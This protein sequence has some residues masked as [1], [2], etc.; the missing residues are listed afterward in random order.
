MRQ[1]PTTVRPYKRTATFDQDSIPA[2]L[3]KSHAT[4][5]G[6]WGRIVVL[7]G[8]LLYRI[9]EPV[10]TETLLLPG[11]AGV[12]EPGI[13]HEVEPDGPVQFYVEFYN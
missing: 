7:Q 6:T 13:R 4:K 9:L 8:R 10:P 11:T 5:T 3:L 12:V 1:L 2:G